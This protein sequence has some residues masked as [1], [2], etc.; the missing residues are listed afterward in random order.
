MRNIRFYRGGGNQMHRYKIGNTCLTNSIHEKNQDILVVYRLSMSQQCT[1]QYV[2]V[3][4]IFKCYK[5]GHEEEMHKALFT[6]C[7]DIEQDESGNNCGMNSRHI[8]S[9]R[10]S[11]CTFQ[12]LCPSPIVFSAFS[13]I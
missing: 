10:V 13:C 12:C 3:K 9:A 1:V 5:E 2:L 8:Y 4:K 6:F 7:K 11:A